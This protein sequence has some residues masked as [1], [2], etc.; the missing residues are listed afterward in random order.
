[1]KTI[2]KVGRSFYAIA[3]LAYGVQQFIY[4]TFRPVFFP[5]WQTALPGLA[6]WAYLFGLWLII[7]G[8]AILVEKKAREIAILTGV[9]FLFLFCFVQVPFE[10][11]SDPYSKFFGSWATALKEIA[12]AGGAFVVASTLPVEEKILAKKSGWLNDPA[13]LMIAGRIL[14]SITITSF[15]I[16]HFLYA[17][18]VAPLVPAWIPNHLFWTYFSGA[19]LIVSGLAI[20]FKI[21]IK[22]A[23]LLLGAT[24]FCWLL[25][26]HIPRAIDQPNAQ[27][28][29]E[30]ASAFDA[31]AFSGIAF[32]IGIGSTR[33]GRNDID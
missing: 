9:I 11:I 13:K 5:A 23:A 14:F 33:I 15:G 18:F 27:R 24:I 28:G 25:V 26:L 4:G 16:Q 12:L 29:N 2:I 3:L 21:I 22:P 20:M 6:V 8:L 32:L 7:A 30:L 31:L 19:A 17:S 10:I 1:M